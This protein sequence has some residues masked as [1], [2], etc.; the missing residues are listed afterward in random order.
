MDSQNLGT[1]SF[2]ASGAITDKTFVEVAA[3]GAVKTFD[4]TGYPLG[5]ANMDAADTQS[6]GVQTRG[7]VRVVAG[8]AV[9]VGAPITSNNEGQA[10]T[11]TGGANVHGIALTASTADGE[12][13]TVC[14]DVKGT[15]SA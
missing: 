6:V 11:A 13:I 15:T 2:K 3:A 1:L 8:A 5:V 14:L 10:I 7:S 12:V 4:G 9:A